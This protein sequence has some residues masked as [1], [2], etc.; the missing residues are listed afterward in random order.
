MKKTTYVLMTV[1]AFVLAM[2]AV[3]WAQL[4]TTKQ[5]AEMTQVAPAAGTPAPQPAPAPAVTVP[6]VPTAAA[7]VV[8]A[9]PIE[10][11]PAVPRPTA[12]QAQTEAFKAKQPVGIGA[13]PS[14]EKKQGAPDDLREAM[15]AGEF[16]KKL[17]F[18]LTEA[19]MVEFARAAIK[20]GKINS[21][22]DV[23]IASTEA[24]Q[25]A[26]EYNNLA[27][28]EIEHALKSIPGLTLEQY[29]ELTRMTTTDS[30]FASI[31]QAYKQLVSE[32][33]FGAVPKGGVV[34][35][36]AGSQV[37]E[38]N[39]AIYGTASAPVMTGI[40]NNDSS[41]GG[42][43][44]LPDAAKGGSKLPSAPVNS[45]IAPKTQGSTTPPYSPPVTR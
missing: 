21:K 10:A 40:K 31:Y 37:E 25:M 4:D 33:A 7:P 16:L 8:S 11:K 36:K 39:T 26:I 32:G 14:S 28:E 27:V 34:P 2:V 45:G 15:Q 19:Q 6:V 17:S 20:V 12:Q 44:V 29:N 5:T 3:S 1:S 9:P 41:A 38:K 24:D 42:S 18:P 35:V 23:Q 43:A 13:V 22:W 30:E